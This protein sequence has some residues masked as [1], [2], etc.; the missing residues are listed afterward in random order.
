MITAIQKSKILQVVNV[1]ETGTK[2][3]KYDMVVIFAD[4]IN[5][6]RQITYGRSQTTEQ[7]NLKALLQL[8]IVKK[9][10]FATQFQPFINDIGKK[11]LVDNVAFKSL[12]RQSAR[13]DV[14]MQNSQDEFFEKL[15]YQPAQH[16]FEK[17]LFKNALSM[18]VIYDSY[19]HSGSIPA[20]L[21]E[22]FPENIPLNGGDEKKWIKQYVDTRHNWLENHSR[23]ILRKTI[24]R[25]QC[26][27]N[28]IATA[29]WDLSKV[30]LA[31]GTS[32]S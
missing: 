2:Q 1:F 20:F 15:Y 32:I 26:F 18:L 23:K 14:I 27:K 12:L 9:G 13:Q 19:I 4:G 30:I 3:G 7:G 6:T 21:R 5:N 17:N 25:T 10:K 31:N 28:Q 22:R 16:F 8:Y 24:Y 11:S 29:N